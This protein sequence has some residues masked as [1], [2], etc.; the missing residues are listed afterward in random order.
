[1]FIDMDTIVWARATAQPCDRVA[2]TVT[3]RDEDG[4]VTLERAGEEQ[5]TSF[6]ALLADWVLTDA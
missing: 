5:A 1:M 2:W 3:A 4:H 6:G